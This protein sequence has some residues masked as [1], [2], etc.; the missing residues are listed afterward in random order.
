[1]SFEYTLLQVL[2]AFGI[3]LV[4]IVEATRQGLMIPRARTWTLFGAFAIVS[5]PLSYLSGRHA[6]FGGQVK[7]VALA[8]I[9]ILVL[10]LPCSRKNQEIG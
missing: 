8:T 3:F 5:A 6:G 7:L 9:V 2:P 10:K 4:C 1:M